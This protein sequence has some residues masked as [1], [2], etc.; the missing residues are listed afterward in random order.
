MG[1]CNFS[2]M[3]FGKTV[4]DAYRNACD[5]ANA[6]NGHQEGYS[7]DIQTTAG[8]IEIQRKGR[9]LSTIEEAV[10]NNPRFEKRGPCAAVVVWGKE[11]TAYRKSHNLVG[12]RGVVVFFCGMAAC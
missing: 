6:Y 10:L 11:A 12:K 5:E 4:A 2:D 1:G 3:A 9:K 7:G 8:Y